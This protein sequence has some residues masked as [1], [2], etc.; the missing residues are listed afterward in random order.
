MG[1]GVTE[2]PDCYKCRH[3]R[4]LPGDRHS[5][6]A[7]PKAGGEATDPFGEMM[8]MFASVGRGASVIGAGAIELGIKASPHGMINGWF[9]WPF[10]FDPV[11]LEGCDGF[12]RRDDDRHES[13]L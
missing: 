7:H 10:N 4:D 5:R 9:N 2:K 11:W 1:L 13:T 12:E 6:C 8:A 3:R